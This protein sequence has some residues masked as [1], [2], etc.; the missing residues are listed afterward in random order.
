LT[1]SPAS[2]WRVKNWSGTNNDASTAAT[3]SLTMPAANHTASVTYESIPGT[4]FR[5]FTPAILDV[6]QTCLS[7]PNEAEPNNTAAAANGP[8]CNGSIYKGRPNDE[9]DIFYVDLKRPGDITVTMSNHHSPDV[10]LALHYQAISSNALDI[11]A[12]GSDGFSVGK[13]NGQ[14]GR[15]FIV[16]YVLKQHTGSTAQ[17]SLRAT[18]TE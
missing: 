18:F 10:Q 2:G 5:A 1:A 8:L 7:G 9:Y 16:I 12:N 11:D 3:I 13:T 14:P 17:Y 6:P 4:T 15:Y